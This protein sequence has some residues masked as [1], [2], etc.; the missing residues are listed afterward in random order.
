MTAAIERE[1][2]EETGFEVTVGRL[3][4]VY[5]DTRL[6]VV[7]YPDGRV[8]HYV[9][10]CFA[11]DLRGGVPGL[12]RERR[13]RS[14]GSPPTP[15]PRTCCRSPAPHRRCNG[16]PLGALHPMTRTQPVVVLELRGPE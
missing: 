4:G 7:R 3:I 15:C 6:Q 11:C 2:R 9:N 16:R 13:S 14:A 5:S 1:V 8:W 12:S 10:L